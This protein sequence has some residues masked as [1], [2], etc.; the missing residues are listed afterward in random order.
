MKKV[1]TGLVGSAVLAG[2]LFYFGSQKLVADEINTQLATLQTHG[3]VIE[4]RIKDSNGEHFVISLADMH[5]FSKLLPEYEAVLLAEDKSALKEYKLGVDLTSSGSDLSVAIYPVSFPTKELSIEDKERVDRYIKEKTLT[6]NLDYNS[7][8]N[9][10][11]GTLKDINEQIK[12]DIGVKLIGLAFDGNFNDDKIA[13]N[14]QL[15]EFKVAESKKSI[16]ELTGLLSEGTY[17]GLNYY[18]SNGT[19]NIDNFL[20]NIPDG[21]DSVK[22]S[23]IK[24][25]VNSEIKNDLFESR[26]SMITKTV[27]ATIKNDTYALDTFTFDYGMKN[28]NLEAFE[29]LVTALDQ[30]N[31]NFDSPEVK[32]SVEAIFANGLV[33]DVYKFGIENITHNGE[34]LKGF[35]L[36][37]NL[38]LDNNP[39]IIQTI[40]TAPM[41]ALSSV[42]LNSKIEISDEIFSKAIKDPRA[43]MAMMVQPKQE[44]GYKVYDIE[45]KDSK[46]EVNG[47]PMM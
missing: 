21:L 39:D 13:L 43:M 25:N 40:Q 36:Q 46:L 18:V 34:T 12:N 27:D 14:Y 16:V 22:F 33:F 23:D 20:V 37:T 9:N 5:K 35:S 38:E 30:Q 2:G 1:L 45:L 11:D 26:L 15:N 17:E 32:K 42:E 31:P 19:T 24:L 4:D 3:F 10:F 44:N 8:T 41:Q 29:T 7:V 28:I 47:L 6:L